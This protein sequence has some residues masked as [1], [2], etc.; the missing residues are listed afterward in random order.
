MRHYVQLAFLALT[1]GY[2]A[3]FTKS[4]LYQGK[5]KQVCLPG[6]NCY[7]CPGAVG[8]CPVGAVQATLTGANKSLPFYALGFLLFFGVLLGRGVCALFCPFGFLQDM[9]YKLRPKQMKF[10]LALPNICRFFPYVVLILFVIVLPLAVTNQFNM[11]DPAFCKWICP[12]GTLLGGIPLLSSSESLRSQVGGLFFWKLSL[13]LGILLWSFLEYRPFCKYLCPLGGFYGLFQSVSLYRM[14]FR[15]SAC[16]GCGNC[17]TACH[18]GVEVRETPNSPHCVRCGDCVKAC[19]H[20]ALSLGI[21]LGE[22]QEQLQ[23]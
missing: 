6:L 1:N 17:T 19:P 3:G 16:V 13:C 5:G 4:T 21:S 8:S 12:S 10:H 22:N 7:S 23:A 9:I 18:M 15:P 20:K 2:L 14:T 11:S